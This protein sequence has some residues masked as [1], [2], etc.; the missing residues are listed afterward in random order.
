MKDLKELINFL[1][2]FMPWLL[3]LFFSGQTF[4]SLERSIII[5]L[6][7]S[8]VFGFKELRR[9]YLLQWGTLIFFIVCVITVDLMK[10]VWVAK[11]MGIISN[12]FLAGLIWGTIFIGKP[13]TLQYARAELPKER[14]DDPALVRSCRFMAIVW[15]LLLTFL[16][17][18]ACLKNLNPTLWPDRANFDVTLAVIAGGIVF[19]SLYKK[20]KRNQHNSAV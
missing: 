11:S 8:L 20:Y 5:G 4:A 13:F 14:W 9:G 15:A 16:A 10:S 2:G 18:T 17:L 7:A 3:F 1:L 12:G 19:T 6:L